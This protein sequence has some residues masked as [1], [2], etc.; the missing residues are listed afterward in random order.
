MLSRNVALCL[1]V[2]L[3][4]LCSCAP[5]PL[6][7]NPVGSGAVHSAD[8]RLAGAWGQKDYPL[9]FIGQSIDGWMSFAIS[10]REN[11][12]EKILGKMYVSKM[13]ERNFLNIKIHSP[14]DL[15]DFYVIAEYRLD[16]NDRLF[17][18]L[19]NHEFVRK[20]VGEGRL[21]G[22]VEKDF[23]ESEVLVV[24]GESSEIRTL[25]AES[26]K[27]TLFPESPSDALKR[28]R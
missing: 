1:A 10:G 28:I 22:R 27:Q 26:P 11:P 5:S 12:D 3:L 13:G 2:S 25:I 14:W 24:T 4:L 9:L 23:Y 18:A 20:A 7:V 8:K 19:P 17:V 15:G 16:G 6:W 21:S